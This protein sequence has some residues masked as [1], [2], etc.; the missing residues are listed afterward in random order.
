MSWMLIVLFLDVS[1][2]PH[3][4]WYRTHAACQQ[5]VERRSIAVFGEAPGISMIECQLRED[6]RLIPVGRAGF[7]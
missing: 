2:M 4:S 5:Q 1:R 3:I 7:R 6:P